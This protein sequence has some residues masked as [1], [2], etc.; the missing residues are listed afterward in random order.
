M[1]ANYLK[2]SVSCLLFLPFLLGVSCTPG[3]SRIDVQREPYPVFD[4]VKVPDKANQMLLGLAFPPLGLDVVPAL[5]KSL[6]DFT[7]QEMKT[8]KIHDLR[9]AEDWANIEPRP[10]IFEWGPLEQHLKQLAQNDLQVFLTISAHGPDWRCQQ[11][12]KESCVYTDLNAFA[13]FLRTLLQKYGTQIQR[14]QF[15]NEVLNPDYYPGTIQEFLIAWRIFAETVREESPDLELVL[16]G[17]STE[18]LRRFAYCE[19]LAEI[20][21]YHDSRY[22]NPQ[23]RSKFCAQDW[24]IEGNRA[25]QALLNEANF[26]TVDLHL[27]D[28]AEYWP[29]IYDSIQKRISGKN[30]VVSEFGGPNES[31]EDYSEAY[32]AERLKIYLETLRYLPALTAAYYAKLVPS[33]SSSLAHRNSTLYQDSLPPRK[34][35]SYD[36]FQTFIAKHL[37]A[38]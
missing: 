34:K 14:I 29:T 18:S 13:A 8:L 22:S 21:V 36:V 19:D 30:I 27:Y 32:Q 28:D 15:G 12:S 35:A 2:K 33:D 3:F 24:V 20:R 17:F 23:D 11:N 37:L 7:V 38:S 9:M 1:S 25:L 16:P 5:N 6:L 31:Y 10:N 4:P 26:D